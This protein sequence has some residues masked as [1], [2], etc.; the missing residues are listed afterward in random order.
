MSINREEMKELLHFIR[1]EFAKRDEAILDLKNTLDA[2]TTFNGK[3]MLDSQDIHLFLQVCDR[4][5]LRWCLE[6]RLL[7][8]KIGRKI[9]N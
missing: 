4:T 1:E 8:F 2:M 7:Y 5:Q 3:Q 6:S 9:Y